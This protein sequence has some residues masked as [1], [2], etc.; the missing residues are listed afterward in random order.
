[1]AFEQQ[2]NQRQN[3]PL[4]PNL[5]QSD[6]LRG[7]IWS[8]P[9]T[10]TGSLDSVLRPVRLE[11]DQLCFMPGD[12]KDEKPKGAPD[13][14]KE[15][16]ELAADSMEKAGASK[17]FTN[18]LNAI[19]PEK[20]DEISV[21]ELGSAIGKSSIKGE[22]AFFMAAVKARFDQFEKL[23]PSE[24]KTKPRITAKSMEKFEEMVKSVE[25]GKCKDEKT[26]EFVKEVLDLVKTA[27]ET[28]Q[29]T[30]RTLYVDKDKPLE[31]IKTEA[32]KQASIGNC[33]FYGAVAALADANP[34][35]IQ[36]MITP[37]QGG[38]YTVNF[39]GKK[40]ITVDAPSDGELSLYPKPGQFG[41]W[42]WVLEKAYGQYCMNNPTD[43]MFRKLLKRAESAVPQEHTE[44]PSLMD[45]GLR[46]L[47]GKG[48]GHVW[49][50]KQDEM[51]KVLKDLMTE[52][53]RRPITTDATF[54]VKTGDGAAVWAH[55][56]S[57]LEYKP[58]TKTVIARN[59]WGYGTPTTE[60]VKDLGD[61]KFS[62]SLDVFCK[63]FSRISYPEK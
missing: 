56:Y 12:T 49:N 37:N 2:T 43:Q 40:P 7:N 27:R 11:P 24:D 29:R 52:K 63:L 31:S 30:V 39:P 47:T 21:L 55:T 54:N 28:A 20:K 26:I 58:D 57:V 59:P 36:D 8:T 60:G 19:K 17:S 50:H 18:L 41:T 4:N 3:L 23:D 9:T 32:V 6:L 33:Y 15:A 25:S 14:S 45:G 48:M 61:G 22:T 34:K 38:T 51:E 35:A 53:P 44:G 5:E 13:V 1:M 16:P 62:M 46:V 10:G 42:M